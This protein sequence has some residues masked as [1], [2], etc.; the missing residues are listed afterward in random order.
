MFCDNVEDAPIVFIV[1]LQVFLCAIVYIILNEVHKILGKLTIG[2]YSLMCLKSIIAELAAGHTSHAL[3]ATITLIV[4][5]CIWLKEVKENAKREAEISKIPERVGNYIAQNGYTSPLEFI[6]YSNTS[7]EFEEARKVKFK[8]PLYEKQVKENEIRKKNKQKPIE[9]TEP[10]TIEYGLFASFKY[11]EI[12]LTRFMLVIPS[13]IKKMY[14]FDYE[15]LFEET[16]EFR[17][18]FTSDTGQTDMQYFSQASIGVINQL[19]SEDVIERIG[20]SNIFRSKIIPEEEGNLIEGETLE[21][22]FD[23]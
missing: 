20:T 7:P 14:M 12:V 22:S 21:I 3:K 6:D 16:P 11:R 17:D 15:N 5:A 13:I 9:I 18:F 4:I 2:V 1:L 19:I 8:N 23:D 10:E